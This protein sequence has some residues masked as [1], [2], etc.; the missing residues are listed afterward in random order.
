M[1]PELQSAPKTLEMPRPLPLRL[2]G[3]GNS[4]HEK[5]A[6]G[7]VLIDEEQE[8]A[9]NSETDL[10]RQRHEPHRGHGGS[11]GALLIHRDGT[12]VL[13]L[14]QIGKESCQFPSDPFNGHTEGGLE[15]RVESHLIQGRKTTYRAQTTAGQNDP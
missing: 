4:P 5:Q 1:E 7:A 15:D 8:G 14:F 9:V 3:V 10:G 2:G 6:T 12:L 11:L 13:E